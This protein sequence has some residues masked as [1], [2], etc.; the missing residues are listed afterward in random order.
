MLSLW[1]A[2]E[3]ATNR[4]NDKIESECK[5]AFRVDLMTF[6]G[7][8]LALALALD[9]LPVA[10]APLAPVPAS[11]LAG[12]S[13]AVPSCHDI[14]GTGELSTG[15]G[16]LSAQ[17]AHISDSWLAAAGDGVEEGLPPVRVLKAAR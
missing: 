11:E 8:L 12:E 5:T 10:A 9:F 7:K 15:T 1:P 16:K 17:H 2:T 14:R 6:F 3:T 13:P 4:N